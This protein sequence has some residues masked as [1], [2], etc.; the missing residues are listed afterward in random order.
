MQAHDLVV[1]RRAHDAAAGAQELG[2]QQHGKGAP[3][4]QHGDEGDQVLDPDDFVIRIEGEVAAPAMLVVFLGLE[5]KPLPGPIIPDSDPHEPTDQG[6]DVADG[7]AD[8]FVP[9]RHPG[10][11][12]DRDDEPCPEGE[13]DD[14]TNNPL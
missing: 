7:E 14:P 12:A 10:S 2:S 5:A 11:Q 6:K 3:D 8:L 9:G 4:Q 13:T 1:G